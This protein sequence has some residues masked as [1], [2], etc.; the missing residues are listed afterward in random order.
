M[1]NIKKATPTKA[2]TAQSI[3][4][5]TTYKA[6][7]S[8]SKPL[9]TATYI[10]I[11]CDNLFLFAIKIISKIDKSLLDAEVHCNLRKKGGNNDGY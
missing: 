1:V 7:F 3:N 6:K 11:A 10:D 8:T 4:V 2:G 5:T 9:R